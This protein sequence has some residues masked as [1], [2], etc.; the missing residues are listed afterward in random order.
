[1]SDA[2]KQAALDPGDRRH[3]L[4]AAR[5]PGHLVVS[6]MD[7]K[8]PA[9]ALTTQ[10]RQLVQQVTSHEELAVAKAYRTDLKENI[11][12]TARNDEEAPVSLTVKI[13]WGLAAVA[14]IGLVSFVGYSLLRT[15]SNDANLEDKIMS[16]DKAESLRALKQQSIQIY[17]TIFVIV[18]VV[19]ILVMSAG[20][21]YLIYFKDATKHETN[22]T[23]NVVHSAERAVDFNEDVISRLTGDLR[24]QVAHIS[25]LEHD[26][27]K[28]SAKIDE[29]SKKDDKNQERIR[30]L[31]EQKAEKVA[32]LSEA[33]ASLKITQESL[34]E[35]KVREEEK[36]KHLRNKDELIRKQSQEAAVTNSRMSRLQDDLR[37]E[38]SE[39]SSLRSRA[40]LLERSQEEYRS[41]MHRLEVDKA[42]LTEEVKSKPTTIYRT[43]WI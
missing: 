21:G 31:M 42:R 6:S 15:Q 16:G 28:Y 27:D 5:S 36:D 13:C 4:A 37:R 12:D 17:V 26:V 43:Y 20:F 3:D 30:E 1:M 14:V 32:E 2:K 35:A 19:L 7:P 18:I 25:N 8:N 10:T 29:L 38:Q 39:A 41:R 34:A 9:L 22:K 40:S 33:K 11:Y 23:W 24:V